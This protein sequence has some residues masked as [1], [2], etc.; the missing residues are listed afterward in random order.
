MTISP[1]S[2]PLLSKM[3]F[4]TV[5]S[6][7]NCD[8]PCRCRVCVCV[9]QSSCALWVPRVVGVCVCVLQGEAEALWT[10]K[11]CS[12]QL[13]NWWASPEKG[14]V[15][16]AV[17]ELSFVSPVHSLCWRKSRDP[18]P[19]SRHHCGLSAAKMEKHAPYRVFSSSTVPPGPP[20]VL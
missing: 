3:F 8:W 16:G 4:C 19:P 10:W 17:G 1:S 6:T 18:A 5:L 13:L 15:V 20:P 7:Q 2:S 12:L 11:L 9:C 14:G